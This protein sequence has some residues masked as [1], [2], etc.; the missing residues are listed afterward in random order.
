MTTITNTTLKFNKAEPM[1]APVDVGEDGIR[2]SL[3]SKEDCKVLIMLEAASDT[4]A[5]VVAGGGIQAV[6]DLVLE[7]EGGNAHAVVLESGMYMQTEGE[8]K[9]TVVIKGE[10]LKVSAIE[11]P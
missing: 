10:N 7:L 8:H 9:G 2:V 6:N 5:T 3:E 4:E 11:L 1:P